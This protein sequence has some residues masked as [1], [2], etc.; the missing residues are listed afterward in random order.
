MSLWSS[1]SVTA[2]KR[3][4]LSGM[5]GFKILGDS[6]GVCEICWPIGRNDAENKEKG[7]CN[8]LSANLND[9]NDSVMAEDAMK[10]KCFCVCSYTCLSLGKGK[11]F[12]SLDS[13][14]GQPSSLFFRFIQTKQTNQ[15]HVSMP[16]LYGCMNMYFLWLTSCWHF[17]AFSFRIISCILLFIFLW[18]LCWK[19]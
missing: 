19:L 16:L 10:N 12:H 14:A 13:L 11:R 9:Y 8:I 6:I 17:K 4:R 3:W 2:L 7:K 1:W 18:C 5:D 15:K